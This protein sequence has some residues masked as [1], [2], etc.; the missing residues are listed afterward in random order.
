MACCLRSLVTDTFSQGIPDPIPPYLPFPHHHRRTTTEIL[1]HGILRQYL[2]PPLSPPLLPIPSP[3]LQTTLTPPPPPKVEHN[4]PPPSSSPGPP[5]RRPDFS[6]FFTALA[7]IDTS[8]TTNPHAVPLPRD[9]SAAYRRLAE[10]LARMR[11]DNEGDGEG[12]VG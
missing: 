8:T 9:V 7:N 4:V 12:V 6:T 3:P 5:P 10:G 11:E 1:N 2:P